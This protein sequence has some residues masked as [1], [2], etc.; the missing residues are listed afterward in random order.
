MPIDWTAANCPVSTH[1]TVR[2]AIG[3]PSWGGRLA[4]PSDFPGQPDWETVTANV[5]A[6]MARL[7]AVRDWFGSPIRVH[8]TVRP[9]AYNLQIGGAPASSHIEGLA[10]DF[11]V[12][13]LECCDAI[14]RV[15][16]QGMLDTWD[17]RMENNGPLPGWVHLDARAPGPGGRYFKP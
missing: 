11:D 17:L 14:K 6:F 16:D 4:L 10:C 7:D 12:Q 9:P 3:L 1:F 2:E 5:A 13:G 8:V 15:L